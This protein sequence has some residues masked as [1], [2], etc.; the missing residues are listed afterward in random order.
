MC[1]LGCAGATGATTGTVGGGGACWVGKTLTGSALGAGAGSS[2]HA[3]ILLFP[4]GR[5]AYGIEGD[6]AC[7]CAGFGGGVAAEV[8]A[9]GCARR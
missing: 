7:A 8:D 5:G 1:N 3:G 4:A 9:T 6:G 2:S